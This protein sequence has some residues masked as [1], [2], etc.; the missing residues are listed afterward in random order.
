MPDVECAGTT[1]ERQ[2]Y[3]AGDEMPLF[4]S[5][6]P[7]ERR[8]AVGETESGRFHAGV[9]ILLYNFII[10]GLLFNGLRA[11]KVSGRIDGIEFRQGHGWFLEKYRAVRATALWP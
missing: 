2:Q 3:V 9:L 8:T 4:F 5:F 1:F 6:F 7:V 11:A 10:P